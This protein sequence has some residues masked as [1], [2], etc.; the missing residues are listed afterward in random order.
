MGPLDLTL[1][2]LGFFAPAMAVAALVAA[3]SRLIMSRGSAGLSA[4]AHAAINFVVG[5]LVLT[6]GLWVFGVDGKMLTY[7]ALVLAVASS[8]WLS[9]RAWQK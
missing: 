9:S 2:L 4:W 8:Q 5:G 3:A 7:A 6:A 1:H